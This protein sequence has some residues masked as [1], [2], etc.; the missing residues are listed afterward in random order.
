MSKTLVLRITCANEWAS[1]YPALFTV[2]LSDEAISRIK[3][4]SKAVTELGLHAVEEFDYSGTWVS[5]E[6]DEDSW[7]VDAMDLDELV[8]FDEGVDVPKL[9]VTADSFHFTALP[10]H[11]RDDMALTT[12]RVP[13]S[14]LDSADQYV[15]I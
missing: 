12:R 1:N 8:K 13:I 5:G 9:R 2:V 4:L 7:D 15:A 6:V 14:A 3:A 10:K 11:C